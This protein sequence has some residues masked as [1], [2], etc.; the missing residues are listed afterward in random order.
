MNKKKEHNQEE[1]VLPQDGRN[2]GPGRPADAAPKEGKAE[3]QAVK[4]APQ[5]PPPSVSLEDRIRILEAES[6]DL[7]DK[8]L[9]KQADFE[10]FRKRMLREREEAARYANAALLSDLMGLIDD[11]ERA[12]KSAEDSK[13]FPGFLTGISMIEKRFVELLETR[14]GLKRFASVG[15]G[16]DPNRHEAVLK[17]EGPA[18][19]KPTVVEDYQKGYYLHERVLRPAKVKVMVP[20]A[21]KTEAGPVQQQGAEPQA[22]R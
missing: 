5:G 1:S 13:D 15:E 10:N 20:S 6:I 14:W 18:D 9:R 12:I 17:V 19:S 4:P 7:K 2:Q 8:M 11:F 16:F 3:P 21:P 22:G